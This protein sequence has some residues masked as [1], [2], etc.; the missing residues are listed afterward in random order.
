[1][2]RITAA[3]ASTIPQRSTEP[4]RLILLADGSAEVELE[5]EEGVSAS[6][7]WLSFPTKSRLLNVAGYYYTFRSEPRQGRVDLK[8]NVDQQGIGP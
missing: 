8:G 2:R 7:K 1:M 5:A 6:S 3:T 4:R